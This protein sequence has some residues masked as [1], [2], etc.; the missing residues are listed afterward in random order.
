[1]LGYLILGGVLTVT[2]VLPV[3][4]VGVKFGKQQLQPKLRG[5]AGESKVNNCLRKFKGKEFAHVKDVMLP[6]RGKTSQIDNLLISPYGIFVI[7]MKNYKGVIKGCVDQPKWLQSLPGSK[8]KPREFYNPIW[9]NEGH[10]RALKALCARQFPNLQYHNIVVFSDECKLP[11]IPNVIRL[12]DLR[13][14]LKAKMKDEPIISGE[15]VAY[16]KEIIETNNIKGNDKRLEHVAYA[17][18]RAA[19]A[20]EHEKAEIMK[21]RAE[22]N[23]GMADKVQEAYNLGRLS[24]SQQIGEAE[25]IGSVGAQ[26]NESNNLE[27]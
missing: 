9:Q 24:L 27:R 17:K 21:N 22:A 3:I 7:E 20:R 2:V 16:I 13:G 10:I 19:Q 6:S 25:K 12:K 8:Y 15:D 23:K 11:K 14:A 4:R 5:K 18:E 26:R 1:M